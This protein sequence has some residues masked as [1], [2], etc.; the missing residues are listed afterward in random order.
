[1]TLSGRGSG[2]VGD[3]GGRGGG[4]VEFQQKQQNKKKEECFEPFILSPDQQK[5][6]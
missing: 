5:I 4:F 1:M 2:G 3:D 6:T